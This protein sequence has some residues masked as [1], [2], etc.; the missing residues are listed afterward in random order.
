[1]TWPCYQATPSLTE[2]AGVAA[3]AGLHSWY[4]FYRVRATAL[5]RYVWYFV[6]SCDINLLF[7]DFPS[8]EL[9][10]WPVSGFNHVMTMNRDESHI[11]MYCIRAQHAN[12]SHIL[13]WQYHSKRT[14]NKQQ[15]NK[16]TTKQASK[17]ASKQTNK[18]ASKQASKQ[19]AKVAGPDTTE[20]TRWL[21]TLK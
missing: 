21:A 3:A 9:A 14:A 13:P 5:A 15:T 2:I 17:Q 8:I 7:Q 6:I 19:T 20:Q 16:Q 11:S 1:M 18:Q 4:F 10:G 12:T